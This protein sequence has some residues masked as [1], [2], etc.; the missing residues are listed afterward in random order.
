MSAPIDPNSF[1]ACFP[2]DAL[3]SPKI[4][5]HG[6]L[7]VET[8]GLVAGV[9]VATPM[10]YVAAERLSAGDLVLAA[11]GRHLRLRW[12]GATRAVA[13]GANAPVCIGVGVRDNM[14][15][16]RLAQ[17]HMLHLAHWRAE[18]LF[19]APVVLAPA[20]SFV[21]GTTVVLEAGRHEVT[22][23]HLMVDRHEVILVENVPCETLHP[24]RDGVGKLDPDTRALLFAACP[25]AMA[26][27]ATPAGPEA[28]LRLT[29]DEAR[30]L[31]SE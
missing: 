22:F 17:G 31:R 10:G 20:R 21:N 19:G 25:D 12:V 28:A 30:M 29:T 6:A 23:I 18:R 15:P 1:K 24:G 13:R 16:L 27:C 5:G 9:R 2:A 14:R 7:D 8:L 26:V 4:E 3:G 11:D